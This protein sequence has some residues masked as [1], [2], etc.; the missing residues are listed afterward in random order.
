[1]KAIVL[2]YPKESASL[3]SVK[4][5][6]TVRVITLLE[7]YDCSIAN[8]ADKKDVR[9]LTQF[10]TYSLRRYNHHR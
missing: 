8:F 3:N 9:L 1:M 6:V 7:I 4:F 2:Q 5:L 10:A